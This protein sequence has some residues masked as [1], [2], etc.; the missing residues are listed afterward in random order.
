MIVSS[1]MLLAV[2]LSSS[3]ASNPEPEQIV[4]D[5]FKKEFST[6]QN[7]RWQKEEGYDKAIFGLAGH[8]VVAYYNERAELEGCVRDMFFVQ[9]PLVVMTAVEKRYV[10]APVFSVREISNANGTSYQLVL[11]AKGKRL[12]VRLAPDGNFIETTRVSR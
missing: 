5:A 12:S 10:N 2:G 7:V 3:I 11:E 9:L 1:M 4:L 6:A 8:Q